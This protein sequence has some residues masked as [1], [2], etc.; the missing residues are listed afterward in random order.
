M[1]KIAAN[2]AET[3]PQTIGMKAKIKNTPEV[4]NGEKSLKD[5]LTD[6]METVGRSQVQFRGVL[7]PKDLNFIAGSVAKTELNREEIIVLKKA[8]SNLLEKENI[9]NLKELK[10]TI[11]QD[12]DRYFDFT[13]DIA[14]EACKINPNV[15]LD[16]IS[17]AVFA[18][19]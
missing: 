19:F 7:S 2:G 16:K 12:A 13:V 8:L 18:I 3:I 10:K 9:A 11:T 15:N 6:P 14:N 17:K 4:D 1:L 5:A